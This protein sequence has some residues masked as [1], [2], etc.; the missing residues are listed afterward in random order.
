MWDWHF[1]LSILPDFIKVMRVTI[2]AT[3]A[4]FAVAATLG[5][6]VAL[7]RRAKFKPL[8]AVA[9][10]VVEFIR[11]T[12]LLVQLYF[13][14]YVFPEHGV[15]LSPFVAGTLGLGIHYSA[16][17]AEVYRSGIDVIP[18]GQWEAARALNF[19][20]TQT[21]L[22]II[23][24]QAIRPILPVLGNYL[25]VMF[26]ETP[27]LSAITLVEMLQAAKLAGAQSFR[28]FEPFTLVGLLF[29]VMSYPTALAFRRLEA[30]LSLKH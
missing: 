7:I 13:I 23:L 8:A 26:K 16:Y 3:F 19:S 21:W 15:A 28:Y 22:R 17:L 20:Q 11:S 25:L 10:W 18:Q 4:A 9:G 29:L 14:F 5:L 6:A 1:A 24:P 27:I 2:A 12:P 30:R